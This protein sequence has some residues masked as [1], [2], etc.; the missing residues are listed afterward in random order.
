M[1]GP[2]SGTV[3][4]IREIGDPYVILN[5]FPCG[6][7]SR[8]L[9]IIVHKDAVSPPVQKGRLFRRIITFFLFSLESNFFC[10]GP[11]YLS[12]IV[13]GVF[14][15]SF[16]WEREGTRPYTDQ[17]QEQGTTGEKEALG[18]YTVQDTFTSF[19]QA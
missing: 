18:K 10:I 17:L 9:S 13:F 1:Q 15:H 3:L 6:K 4:C 7:K 19:L 11:L 2:V 5:S 16:G 12:G 14:L 8:H